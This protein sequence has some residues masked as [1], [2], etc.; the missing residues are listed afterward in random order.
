MRFFFLQTVG[1]VLYLQ[2]IMHLIDFIIFFLFT[3]GIV[4]FG[5]SFF[6][7]KISSEEFVSGG[8]NLPGWVVGMSIFSTYVSSI[9]YLGYPGMAYAGNWNA[10]VFSLSIPVA[11]LFAVVYFVPFYRNL[12]CVSAYSYL[13]ERFGLWARLYASACYL[14]T[15]MARIGTILFLMALPMNILLGW[16]LQLV[17]VLSS[18]AI[19]MYSMFGGIKAVIWTEA[20][21]GIVLIGGTIVCM[22]VLL[23]QTPG[24]PS[25]VV[26]TA[27]ADGKFSLGSFSFELSSSTFWVC[28]VYGIFTNLQNYGI[29]QSYVQRYHAAKSEKQ[30]KFSAMFSAFLFIPVSAFF[31][32]IGTSLYVFYKLQPDLLP[33]SI[34]RADDVFPYFIV[35]QLPVGL[36]GL[37]IAS[38][39]A[40]GMSTV[41]TSISSSSTIILTDYY[42]R[43]RSLASEKER[44]R[45]LK[46]SGVIVGLIGIVV[47][48]LLSHVDGI[49]D[50]WWKLSS[51]F[52]GGM[53]GLFLLAFVSKKVGNVAAALAVIC[54]V[55]II[56]FISAGTMLHGYLAIVFGTVVIFCSGFLFTMILDRRR[57]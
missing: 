55:A 13:E 30:A 7:K 18:V 17:I 42:V 26:E 52:S 21:Q 9:S 32:M 44:I 50:A 33:A 28:F 15:Q 46:I 36:T 49:L 51:V 25:N 54:G 6:K 19:I 27:L 8:R 43:V 41:A 34:V 48:I 2:S 4:L 56:G 3:G 29:D 35:H 24:G 45:V 5:C 47:A 23:F 12:G 31:F 39:F 10:F 1:K 16:D 57:R 40:S 53:L 38:I 37:L 11:A 20:L 22:L 14:L